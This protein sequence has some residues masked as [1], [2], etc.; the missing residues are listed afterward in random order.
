MLALP[1]VTAEVPRALAAGET[2]QWLMILGPGAG[3][4][5]KLEGRAEQ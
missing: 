1:V 5:L 3:E 4:R 2:D